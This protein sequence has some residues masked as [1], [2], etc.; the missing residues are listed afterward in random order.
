MGAS[1]G[2]FVCVTVLKLAAT[3]WAALW[4][5]K[6]EDT[7]CDLKTLSGMLQL[8]TLSNSNL[9]V[10][11]LSILHTLLLLAFLWQAT[12]P[13]NPRH[14]RGVLHPPPF[15]QVRCPGPPSRCPVWAATLPGC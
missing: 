14:L 10:W 13:S 5:L 2:V 12:V 7:L 8:Y 9:D 4:P 15:K 6:L 3:T 11:L 1:L